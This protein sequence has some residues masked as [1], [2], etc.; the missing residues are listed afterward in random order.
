M[1]LE[2]FQPEK[3]FELLPAETVV[4]PVPLALYLLDLPLHP[5]L[6]Y[7]AL[8]CTNSLYSWLYTWNNTPLR[9]SHSPLCFNF[10]MVVDALLSRWVP[11]LTRS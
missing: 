1:F 4:H 5:C 10:C 9:A 11:S 2:L 3:H 7:Q 8:L 6:Y